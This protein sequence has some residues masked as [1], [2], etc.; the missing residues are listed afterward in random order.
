MVTIRLGKPLLLT[1]SKLVVFSCRPNSSMDYMDMYSLY[2][3]IV[4]GNPDSEPRDDFSSDQTL[5]TKSYLLCLTL[6]S[7]RLVDCKY[8]NFCLTVRIDLLLKEQVLFF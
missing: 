3:C 2:H 5:L 8:D 4:E 7:T 1:F 6:L